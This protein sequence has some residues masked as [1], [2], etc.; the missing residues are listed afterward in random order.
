MVGD[1][2]SFVENVVGA[3]VPWCGEFWFVLYGDSVDVYAVVGVWYLLL[4]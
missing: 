2:F 1:K 4:E 3:C